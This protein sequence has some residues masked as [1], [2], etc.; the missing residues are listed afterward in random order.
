MISSLFH[1]AISSWMPFMWHSWKETPCW[2]AWTV[3]DEQCWAPCCPHTTPLATVILP[4]PLINCSPFVTHLYV[5]FPITRH[6]GNWCYGLLFSLWLSQFHFPSPFAHHSC[7]FP[8]TMKCSTADE[9]SDTHT[10]TVTVICVL[11]RSVPPWELCSGLI[12][13][14]SQPWCCVCISTLCWV[15]SE[16]PSAKS[17]MKSVR[18][19]S[20][21]ILREGSVWGTQHSCQVW[22]FW[23]FLDLKVEISILHTWCHQ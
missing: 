21:F 18:K 7:F 20:L 13:L 4:L 17:N 5:T 6:A 12:C 2:S 14:H 10:V 19:F 11:Q 9:N 8:S 22:A 23:V 1:K 16:R 3:S 15:F